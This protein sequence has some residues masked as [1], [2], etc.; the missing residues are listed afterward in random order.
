MGWLSLSNNPRPRHSLRRTCQMTHLHSLNRSQIYQD[1]RGCTICLYLG[2]PFI[3]LLIV[4]LL[5]IFVAGIYSCIKIKNIGNATPPPQK[6]PQQ[7]QNKQTN[8]PPPQ[9]NTMLIIYLYLKTPFNLPLISSL[10]FVL[11]FHCFCKHK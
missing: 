1:Q 2:M 9:D 10:F 8:N 4:S 3:L 5:F 6:T 7:K 11:S